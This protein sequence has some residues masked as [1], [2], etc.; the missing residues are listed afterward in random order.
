MK[1]F[2][3]Y[4]NPTSSLQILTFPKGHWYG[5]VFNHNNF[6]FENEK[7]YNRAL[8]GDSVQLDD[9]GK[10]INVVR[11]NGGHKIV[12][13]LKLFGKHKLS[14]NAK[15]VPT[16]NFQPRDKRYP[17]MTVCSN[18]LKKENPPKENIFCVVEFMDW[19]STMKIPR[20][21]MYNIIGEISDDK[22]NFIMNM[23]NRGLYRSAPKF[24]QSYLLVDNNKSIRYDYTDKTVFSIDPEGCIDIDDAFHITQKSNGLYEIG[25]HISDVSSFIPE[26]S[27][28]DIIAQTNST[29]IYLPHQ[30]YNMLPNQ[31]ADDTFSLHE[32]KPR[33]VFTTFI[34][35]TKDGEINDFDFK[36]ALILNRKAYTYDEANH[37]LLKE[38]NDK[39][40]VNLSLKMLF[41]IYEKMITKFNFNSFAKDSP[42]KD[43]HDLVEYFMVLTNHIV[44]KFL[45]NKSKEYPAN[46]INRIHKS[47]DLVKLP[48][49]DKSSSS[50]KLGNFMYRRCMTAAEYS[51]NSGEHF[52]LS[53]SQYLH[54]TSPIR[55]YADILA[56]RFLDEIIQN[57]KLCNEDIKKRS[58][59]TAET[60]LHMNQISKRIK[61]LERDNKKVIIS[62]ELPKEGKEFTANI[63]KIG[64]DIEGNMNIEIYIPDLDFSKEICL[65]KKNMA[66]CIHLSQ[67]NDNEYS[68]FHGE[69]I[70]KIK[71]YDEVKIK[72]IP[73][74]QSAAIGRK[75]RIMWIEPDI[76]LFLMG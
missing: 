57:N 13:V 33:S 63:I 31:F 34:C 73:S 41:R 12:G 36:H 46:F 48:E 42:I 2:Q 9:Q 69:N 54:F 18:I 7:D 60:C 1:F 47:P 38:S 49:L 17:C 30:K 44:C 15:G 35:V 66:H 53:I 51:T 24:S 3:E 6:N 45:S 62:H 64:D 23:W 58:E 26:N 28:L 10:V 5:S 4:I 75:M 29:S 65:W 27:P 56:H 67:L 21:T 61:Q 68:F 74:T 70:F 32:G 37:E 40:P 43:T 14:P 11:K 22:N 55:R 59:K 19:T 8:N 52:G 71:M 76:S 50:I 72:I 16:Y 39:N 20:G 25:V